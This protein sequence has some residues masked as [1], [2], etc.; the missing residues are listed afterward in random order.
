MHNTNLSTTQKMW[1]KRWSLP[2]LVGFILFGNHYARDCL[3]ALEKQLETDIGLTPQEYSNLNSFY[4]FPNMIT[5]LFAG[6][7]VEKLGGVAICFIYSLLISSV[8]HIFFSCG[9]QLA[10]KPLIYFGRF[11]AGTMYEFVDALMPITYLGP[12]F[13]TDFQIVTGF[14]QIFIRMG[15]VTNFI[16][17]PILYLKYGISV[18]FWVSTA[19][20]SSGII[21]FL[22]CRQ[23]DKEYRV[24]VGPVNN[25]KEVVHSLYGR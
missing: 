10:N 22:L 18:A 8:G 2:I 4:F 24:P 12:M 21:I 7:L 25:R 6:M 11:I 13:E 16:V 14:I 23:L 1:M 5:P 3:G 17:S 20:A 15:S 9:I 19:I